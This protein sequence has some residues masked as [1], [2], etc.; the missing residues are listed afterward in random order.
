MEQTLTIGM[1]H[2]NDYHGVYFT[3]QDIRKEL[4]FNR[5]YDLL[6]KIQFLVVENT[7]DS[8][9][10]KMVKDLRGKVQNLTVVDYTDRIGTSAARDKIIEEARTNFVLVMDCHVLLCP[11]I[12]ILD[13]LFS[14]LECNSK[15]DDLYTGPLVYDNLAGVST[16]FNDTWGDHM[17]GQWGSAWGCV[18]E[19]DN[20]AGR[21]EDGKVAFFSLEK[22]EKLDKCV[23]CSREFP[24]GI[25][26][27]GHEG[28]LGKEG[29]SKI[30]LN[31]SERPFPI[32][33]QGLGL[34]L[35]RK[36]SWL[37]FNEHVRG[38]G[39]EECYIHEK[40]RA[41]GRQAINLPFLKWLHRFGR[42]EGVEYE[43]TAENKLRNY[44]LEFLELRKDLA[45][46]YKHFV[47]ESGFSI[48]KFNSTVRECRALYQDTDSTI[49][50]EVLRE[51]ETLKLKLKQ[52]TKTSKCKNKKSKTTN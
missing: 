47:E 35:T 14:F 25:D 42:P 28:P 36:V 3:I 18:C 29:Y 2:Y 45:P 16:H 21:N 37:K 22:Q 44:I 5:R 7:P 52:L 34:F 50:A 38:F 23:Y 12:E 15:S 19:S 11:V 6:Q 26:F 39:G 32:F 48:E 10:A 46:I 1:A 40:Y 49:D 20:F 4:I 43:L 31:S 27:N 41:N 8:T 51:I 30:G 17:W 24:K 9:H 13:K 33:A